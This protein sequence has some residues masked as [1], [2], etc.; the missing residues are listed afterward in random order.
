MSHK[1]ASYIYAQ[2][3]RGHRLGEPLWQPEPREGDGEVLLGDVGVIE[4]GRFC[5]LFNVTRPSNDPV[6][7][8][9]VPPG[10]KVLDYNQEAL[11]EKNDDYLG[12]HPIHSKS[13]S[14]LNL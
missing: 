10:F 4:D 12:P 9:G 11:I 2:E 8:S 13:V 1:T 5:R 6:N 3:L 7:K 14:N